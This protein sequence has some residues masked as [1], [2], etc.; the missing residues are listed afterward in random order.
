MAAI[1]ILN[2]ALL[3]GAKIEECFV[4][5]LQGELCEESDGRLAKWIDLWAHGIQHLHLHLVILQTILSKAA[6]NWRIHKAIHL[7]EANRQRKCP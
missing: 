2:P 5:A 1:F 6:Y 7:E 4:D 3:D